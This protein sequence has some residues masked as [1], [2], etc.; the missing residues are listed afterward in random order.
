MN[1][2]IPFRDKETAL[3]VSQ[4]IKKEADTHKTYKIMEV[5]GTHTM[6]IA[7]SGLKSMLPENVELI[8]GPGC[9][10]CV[11]SQGEID[12]FFELLDCGVSVASFGDLL[13]IP[14]SNGETLID[15]RARGADVNVVYSPLDT[16]KLAEDNPDK[17]YTFLGIGF[18]T[19]AP[20]IAA[21][22]MEAKEK[23]LKNLSVL[24]FCKT[25]PAAFDLILS[26]KDMYLDGFL[27]P[28]HVTAVTGVQLYEPLIKAG[29]A[30]VVAVEMLD[31]VY[32]I[33]KQ[34]NNKNFHIVNKYRR[35]VPDI[36]NA[37]AREILAKVFYESD[38]FWRGLG[39]L[40]KSGLAIRQEY[41]EY[42]ALKRFDLKPKNI[43][44]IKGCKCGQVLTGKIKPQDCPLFAKRCTPED[45]VGPCMV[46]GEGTCA[47][48]YK[49]LR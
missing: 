40:K 7:R 44:E 18:E 3:K 45:P 16:L 1:P 13:R 47:A 27:C 30:A 22:I 5:C 31:A 8:S 4:S 21:L 26:D 15:K 41:I 23:G 46:S 12:L 25:M 6:A 11:T 10:V 42:D 20:T 19:T 9:P 34:A 35:V 33:V 43:T 14:G 49:F 32:E 24:S 37:N 36:G 38:A 39:E 28:G 48:Y 2:N 29:K 17:H